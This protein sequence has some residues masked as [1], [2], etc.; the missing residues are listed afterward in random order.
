MWLTPKW[1]ASL[2]VLQ[3][4]EPSQGLRFTLHSRMRASSAGV[5]V[6]GNCP[7]WRLNSPPQ[8]FCP[9]PLIP[10]I[11]EAV[12]AIE[13][14]SDPRPGVTCIQQQN[15]SRTPCLIGSSGLTAGP[16]GQFFAFHWQQLNR[17]AHQH[18]YTLYSAGT[19]H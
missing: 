18:D 5:S 13:L 8:T 15:Q 17:L 6:V 11:D 9:K 12:S 14:F 19:V 4:V 16:L 2:R 3:W 1:A 10:A 7:A